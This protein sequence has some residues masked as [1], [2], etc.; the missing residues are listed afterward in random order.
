MR[1][2]ASIYDPLALLSPVIVQCKM[3]MQQLWKTRV[4]WEDQLT[5]ELKEQWQRLQHKLPIISDIQIGRLVISKEKLRTELHGFPDASELAYG[6]RIYIRSIDIQGNITTRLLCPK[7]RIA[8][9]KR[10]SLPRLE[11]C[12]AMLLADVPSFIKSLED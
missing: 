2:I 3:F 7:S 1:A 8:P 11:L 10:Q 9:L 12:A 5:T 6:A 4:N